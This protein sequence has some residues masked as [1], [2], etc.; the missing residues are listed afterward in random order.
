[1]QTRKKQCEA[2]KCNKYVSNS[3][4]D[5]TKDINVVKSLLH[6]QNKKIKITEKAMNDKTSSLETKTEAKIL[7]KKLKVSLEIYNKVLSIKYKKKFN[8][9]T[10]KTCMDIFC[11]PG[12]KDTLFESGTKMPKS[13]KNRTKKIWLKYINE[14]RNKRFGNKTNVLVDDFYEKLK[15]Y[16]V[17]KYKKDGAISGCLDTVIR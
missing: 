13:I 2:T 1:M 8:K 4:K 9:D 15:P 12:C 17:A 6:K 16:E 3:K 10:L 14:T 11:N 7:L 5:F